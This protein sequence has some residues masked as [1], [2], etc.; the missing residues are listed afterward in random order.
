MII[1]ESKSV[2]KKIGEVPSVDTIDGPEGAVDYMRGAFKEYP[3][4]EQVWVLQLSRK[5]HIKSREMV[6]LGTSTG[7]MVCPSLIFRPAILQGCPAV[8]VVHNHPSG[9]PSPSSADM[10]MCAEINKCGDILKIDMLDFL[11]I[12]H[13]K[14]W[15][16]NDVGLV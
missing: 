3:L 9:D 5:N 14:H 10:R 1:Y 2:Y 12:G 6:A 11:V 15:S 13:N 8:I 7:C 16:A 4:Q